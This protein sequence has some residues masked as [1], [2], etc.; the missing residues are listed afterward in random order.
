MEI[1]L[2]LKMQSEFRKRDKAKTASKNKF[3]SHLLWNT[4]DDCI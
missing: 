2:E 4:F 1:V 3:S